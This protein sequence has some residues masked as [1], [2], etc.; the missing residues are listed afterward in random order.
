MKHYFRAA[1]IITWL[2]LPISVM[3]QNDGESFKQYRQRMR[4]EYADYKKNAQEDFA[5]YRKKVNDEYA[6]F[7]KKRWRDIAVMKGENPPEDTIPPAPPVVCPEEE[8]NKERGS[9]PK[10]VEEDIKPAPLAPQPEPVAPIDVPKPKPYRDTI[11]FQYWNTP[12]QCVIEK[13]PSL[14]LSGLDDVAIAEG[15][16]ELSDGRCEELLYQCLRMRKQ[17]N[18]SD[19][20]Y[21][22]LCDNVSHAIF[23][24]NEATLLY[25]WLYCQSG[26]KMRLATRDNVLYMFS[27]YN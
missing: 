23:G 7:L 25:A 9:T 6:E 14:T 24:N 3:S 11:R 4:Q 20:A 15:W 10:P 5:A 13:R 1:A 26:Y 12:M 21:L 27:L 2:L 19:W 18:L 8:R 22:Q 17:Y 16:K